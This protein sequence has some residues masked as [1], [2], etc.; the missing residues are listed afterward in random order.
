V[1]LDEVI[2]I[3]L[4]LRS[5]ERKLGFFSA[6]ESERFI[7]VIRV[8]PETEPIWNLTFLLHDRE[9]FQKLWRFGEFGWIKFLFFFP[10]RFCSENRVRVGKKKRELFIGGLMMILIRLGD[11]LI[12]WLRFFT[13]LIN[14]TEQTPKRN[15]KLKK[16]W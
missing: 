14:T 5:D 4:E 15:I 12:L 11:D 2:T 8:W 3:T 7:V 9:S 6:V 13:L 16:N 1:K 10:R